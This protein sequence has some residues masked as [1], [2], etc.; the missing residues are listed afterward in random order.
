MPPNDQFTATYATPDDG[1]KAL[2][3]WAH[4]IGRTENSFQISDVID[5]IVVPKTHNLVQIDHTLR[6]PRPPRVTGA[7]TV[8]TVEALIDYT[9]RHSTPETTAWWRPRNTT[10]HIA[11]VVLNDHSSP[12]QPEWGDHRA[13]LKVAF[14]PSFI[15]WS[16]QSGQLVDQ[17]TFAEFI[18]DQL[19]VIIDPA[20][21]DM[22]EVAQSLHVARSSEFTSDRRLAT[23]RVQFGHRQT[24]TA[25]AGQ[26]GNLEVPARLTLSMPVF[27]GA[28]PVEMT[29]RF[30]Y[31][32]T[33][34]V[35]KLGFILDRVT[36]TIDT[37][38]DA[39]RTRFESV[40]GENDTDVASFA[41][42][43]RNTV[44]TP[45]TF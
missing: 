43:P 2:A 25:T 7:V 41:G 8:T 18:E 36:D 40:W 11:T 14:H 31:R 26:S 3:E 5:G 22:L 30:R 44:Q 15:A 6:Q 35:L 1:P 12:T 38:I 17:E 27:D 32:L 29:A 33:S 39:M 4:D 21:A 24:Q 42:I 45:H 23:G 20:A 10:G 34:G 37:A 28:A 19:A 9:N 13:E 16:T